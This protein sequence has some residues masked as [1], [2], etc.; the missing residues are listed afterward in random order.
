MNCS[1][2]IARN[3]FF[4]QHPKMINPRDLAVEEDNRTQAIPEGRSSHLADTVRSIFTHQAFSNIAHRL[5]TVYCFSVPVSIALGQAIAAL[6]LTYWLLYRWINRKH[7]EVL[8]SGRGETIKNLEF[9]LSS[10]LVL[11][12][13][14]ALVGVS[15]LKAL[16]ETLKT[17]FY[18]LLPFCV[19]D[20]LTVQELAPQ[21]IVSRLRSYFFT[22]VL[23]QSIMSIHTIASTVIGHELS[24]RGPGPITESGQIVLILP[25]I[26]CLLLSQQNGSSKRAETISGFFGIT[27]SQA[28]YGG[29]L[30]CCLLLICWPHV[31]FSVVR[32]TDP[33]QAA[34]VIRIVVGICTAILLF[35]PFIAR[36]DEALRRSYSEKLFWSEYFLWSAGALILTALVANLKRGP[37]LGVFAEMIVVGS[38]LSRKLLISV[39][40]LSIL[41]L[42]TVEPART[43]FSNL[44]DDF[45]IGGGRQTMWELGSEMT[46]RYPL[47]V[48]LD[49]ASYMRELDPTVPPLHKH[50]HNNL[51]N[52]AVELGWIGLAL[53]LWLMVLVIRLGFSI[54]RELANNQRSLPRQ[55]RISA[56]ALG[57]ALL[58][59]QVAGLAEYNFG[60]G[61]IR[62]VALL[63]MGLLMGLTLS[64]SNQSIR[65][66]DIV[67]KN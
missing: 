37:W 19:M 40:G 48:G 45:T 55:I 36:H 60:D 28:V 25:L 63:Y 56:L 46:K 54:W 26:L 9:A 44:I 65:R 12:F 8:F 31:L 27:L 29:L 50:M 47:G 35:L 10:F 41:L 15:P 16:P 51:L 67:A 39:L 14:A 34:R 7:G 33:A 21:G 11:G 52:V 5:L 23:S 66:I 22:L 13:I 59:W 62:L 1:R 3:T 42:V 38:F 49:N 58:G 64:L 61:E 57:S 30:F 18:M 43:R 53:Y 4:S 17:T 6:L 24:P 2:I 20:T 32:P